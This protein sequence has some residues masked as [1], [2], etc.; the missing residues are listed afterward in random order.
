MRIPRLV[1]QLWKTDRVPRRWRAAVATVKRYHP[2]W[3]YRLWTD[4]A[5]DDY[6]R[7]AH[8]DFYP[9]FAGFNR[10]IMRVDA[11]RYVLMHDFGGLY[12]DLDYE[13]IRPFEYGNADVVL[14]LE[15]EKAY[16]SSVD[17]IAN[18]V[19]ASVPAHAL[20]RDLIA[21][22]AANPPTTARAHDVGTATGPGLVSR[23]F[24]ANTER[25]TGVV[26]TH[27]PVLSPRRIHGRRERRIYLNNGITHGFHHGWGTWRERWS[28][29]YWKLKLAKLLGLKRSTR[30]RY[31]FD[32]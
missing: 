27:Q 1:H 23:V 32:H 29:S 18:Y 7:S 20:W 9:V 15:F 22:L 2:G 25:Y 6:V 4:A 14:S 31:S 8:A 21:E 19:L 11:F 24:F 16:G 13:F 10:Q 5:M 26:V 30:D 28:R 12:C 3:E 17:Q